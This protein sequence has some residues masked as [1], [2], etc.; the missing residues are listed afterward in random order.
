MIE[1]MKQQSL[2]VRMMFLFGLMVIYACMRLSMNTKNAIISGYPL[3]FF[4]IDIITFLIFSVYIIRTFQLPIR[5]K[6]FTPKNLI[7]LCSGL[8]FIFLFGNFHTWLQMQGFFP[9][10]MNSAN[11]SEFLKRTPF[12]GFFFASI[13]APVVEES[14]HRGVFFQLFYQKPSHWRPFLLILF[15]GLVFGSIHVQSGGFAWQNLSVYSIMGWALGTT[16][17]FN[18]NLRTNILIHFF[19]N[20]AIQFIPG[21]FTLFINQ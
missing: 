3:I 7:C 17:Y 5:G 8:L 1:K 12:V 14:I 2:I 4:I 6:F 20:A 10:D 21:I 16:Y 18:G 9:P 13:M 11:V 15:S 19:N